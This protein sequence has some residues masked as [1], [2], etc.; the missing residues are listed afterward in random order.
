MAL[1]VRELADAGRL[2]PRGLAWTLFWEGL[3]DIDYWRL[4][5][6]KDKLLRIQISSEQDIYLSSNVRFRLGN[7]HLRLNEYEQARQQYQAALPLYQQISD[8]M[9]EANCI[10][11]LGDIYRLFSEYDQARR[12]YEAARPLYQEVG[13]PE[14]DA[15]CLAGLIACYRQ[16]GLMTEYHQQIALAR[17]LLAKVSLYNRA[18]FAS[19]CG[20]VDEALTLLRSALEK[21]EVDIAWAR[22]DPDF[23][24]V[25]DDP[26]F[27]QL[28]DELAAK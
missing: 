16:L 9:G 14:S 18:C 6:A 1:V 13:N 28:L 10:K 12:Q 19:I 22:I 27:R 7:L 11:G 25:R 20:E 23:D 15:I 17:E 3:L 5:S 21:H 26:R 8:R 4:Q 2:S 24:W